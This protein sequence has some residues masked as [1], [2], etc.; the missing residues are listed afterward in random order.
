MNRL[1]AIRE[2]LSTTPQW[3]WAAILV[4]LALTAWALRLEGR[5]WFCACGELRFWISS[6]QSSHTSQHLFDPYSFTHML[7]GFLFYWALYWLVPK[8]DWRWRVWAAV[9]LECAWEL[10]EN[11]PPVIERYRATTAALGYTGDSALNSLGDIVS[12]LFGVL[13]AS[14]L[15]WKLTLA[16]FVVTEIVLLLT[17]RDNLLL[18][19]VMLLLDIEWLKEWQSGATATPG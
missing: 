13:I 14:K 15:G 16:I 9:L 19:V 11:S 3:A 2:R 7:H 1:T 18:N 12:T 17:I 5:D 10:I 6:P 4:T 8:W